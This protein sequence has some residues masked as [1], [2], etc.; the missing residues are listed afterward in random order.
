V[1]CSACVTVYAYSLLLLLL[2]HCAGWS[3]TVP[4]MPA[5][6]LPLHKVFVK[7]QLDLMTANAWMAGARTSQQ[8][9]WLC[10]SLHLIGCSSDL[11][12]SALRHTI[13]CAAFFTIWS[14]VM[15][16]GLIIGVACAA[17][18]R[19]GLCCFRFAA[20]HNT[21]ASWQ[22]LVKGKACVLWYRRFC[23]TAGC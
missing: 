7:S 22:V 3:Q 15:A 6:D 14:M 16:A 4:T 23:E 2:P 20:S 19:V 1:G 13:Q 12:T 21:H 8:N 11:T 5:G 17:S 10:I 18:G 9:I